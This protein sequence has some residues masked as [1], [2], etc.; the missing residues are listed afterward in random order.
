MFSNNNSVGVSSGQITTDRE[1]DGPQLQSFADSTFNPRQIYLYL[2]VIS[3]Y[4]AKLLNSSASS[5]R[6]HHSII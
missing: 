5:F 6:R 2:T 3:N 1:S 4:T